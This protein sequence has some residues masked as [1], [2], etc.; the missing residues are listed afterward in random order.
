M[1]TGGVA[2]KLARIGADCGVCHRIMAEK[3]LATHGVLSF[4]LAMAD[5]LARLVIS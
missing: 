4:F 2:N 5:L 3:P 1:L